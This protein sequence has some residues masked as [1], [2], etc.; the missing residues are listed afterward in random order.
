MI[1]NEPFENSVYIV[2]DIETTGLN[3]VENDI[4]EIFAFLVEKERI[5]KEFHRLVNPGFFIPRRI[6]EITGITNPMLIGQPN[7]RDVIQE[8]DDF[9][10]DYIIIGHNINFDLSFLNRAY[11]IYLN[12]KLNSPS[13]CTLELSKRLLP[14][15]RSHKLSYIADYFNITYNRLH[16]AKDDTFITYEIFKKLM[17]IARMQYKKELTYLHLKSIIK[18]RV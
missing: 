5:T 8:F 16:R 15:L 1:F 14:H 10:K 12:K 6:T 11:N 3:P 18:Q 4:I 13:V 7:I 17:H 2:L 9:I